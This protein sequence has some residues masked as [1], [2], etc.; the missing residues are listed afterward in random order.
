MGAIPAISWA[1]VLAFIDTRMHIYEHAYQ[2]AY[3]FLTPNH[4]PALLPPFQQKRG[5]CDDEDATAVVHEGADIGRSTFYAHFETKD[6]LLEQ[7]CVEMFDHIFEGVNEHCVTHA[8]LRD[9]DL[10]GILAH[11]LYHMRDTHS[12]VCAKL[13]H[14]REPHF[15]AYFSEKLAVLFARK[16]CDM[17][18][19]VPAGFA[20]SVLV[21]SFTQAVSWWFSSNCTSTPEE[22]AGW[23]LAT[24]K[25]S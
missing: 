14:E 17:P 23:F 20:Q 8:D 6:D 9:T 24:L 11:L 25:I 13:L 18:Q 5:A 15:T 19:G 1:S 4:L 10:A 7:M 3:L 22:L 12:G 16:V 21:A 2:Y